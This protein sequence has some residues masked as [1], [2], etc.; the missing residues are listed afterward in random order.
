MY[1]IHLGWGDDHQWTI[2]LWREFRD[3]RENEDSYF[4]KWSLILKAAETRYGWARLDGR[5]GYWWLNRRGL[6]WV[7]RPDRPAHC[8]P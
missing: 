2:L 5:L 8:S 7:P 6:P 1:S 4:Y 3:V